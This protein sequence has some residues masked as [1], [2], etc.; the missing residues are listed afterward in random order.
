MSEFKMF[1]NRGQGLVVTI[2]TGE[3][4]F[5]LIREIQYAVAA[6]FGWPETGTTTITTVAVEPAALDLVTGTYLFEFA[7][8]QRRS[9]PRVVREGSRLFFENWLPARDELYPQSPT[10]FISANGT[11]F[12]YGVDATGRGVLT[13]GEGPRA[14]KG[15][16]QP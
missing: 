1:P 5:N 11:K 3:A 10:T 15:I 9:Q 7:G 4:G 6:E 13:M 14:L 8:G 16:K 2:N 12:S